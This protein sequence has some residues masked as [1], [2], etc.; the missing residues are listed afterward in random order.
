MIDT[1]SVDTNS[2]FIGSLDSKKGTYLRV[3]G[4]RDLYQRLGSWV[5]NVQH[6]HH[7]RT[8]VRDGRGTSFAIDQFVHTTG[9]QSGSHHIYD[10]L[11]CVDVRNQLGNT[12]RCVSA[13]TEQDDARLLQSGGRYRQSKYKLLV[14]TLFS[15][16]LT[17]NAESYHLCDVQAQHSSCLMYLRC[18]WRVLEGETDGK[19][20][21]KVT[22]TLGSENQNFSVKSHSFTLQ[23]LRQSGY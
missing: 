13:L 8:V 12:L 7:C 23:K 15:V 16:F 18:E 17:S 21:S 22:W 14:R 6:F 10:S 19:L 20:G 1:N 11:A 4:F 9:T 3:L 2:R 5:N